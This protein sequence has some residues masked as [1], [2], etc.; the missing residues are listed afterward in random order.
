[1]SVEQRR[2]HARNGRW[3]EAAAAWTLR[4]RG[5]RILARNL[6]AG[7]VEVDI[8]ARRGRVLAVVEVK[9]R[10]D[11]TAG[12]EAVDP[13]KRQRLERAAAALGRDPRWSGLDVRFDVVVVTPWAW[14]H[15]VAD[16]WRA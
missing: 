14:P 7:G 3:A 13:R 10:P 11:R 15:H 5:W 9:L 16:A 6:K 8:L 2:R 12:L 1:M 4:L